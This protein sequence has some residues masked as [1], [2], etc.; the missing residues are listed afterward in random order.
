MVSIAEGLAASEMLLVLIGVGEAVQMAADN[1]L[2]LVAFGH[3]HCVDAA[4][5]F[6]N[7]GITSHEIDK[8]GSLHQ[9]LRHQRVVVVVFR[10][11]A[12]SASPGLF[13]ADRMRNRCAE[14]FR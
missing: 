11:V 13:R 10:Y 1:R 8:V 6:T 14:S 4:S 5:C 9:Q 2:G 12:V 7:P 3:R